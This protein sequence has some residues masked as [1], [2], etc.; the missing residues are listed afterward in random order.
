MEGVPAL[1]DYQASIS[2]VRRRAPSFGGFG[3]L[4][5]R[6]LG[7]DCGRD[8][9]FSGLFAAVSIDQA[10]NRV[11]EMEHINETIIR[12]ASNLLEEEK[13]SIK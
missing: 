12:K 8:I 9:I 6:F 10:S 4:R 5:L 13:V 2:A 3:G 11:E 7:P 1:Q